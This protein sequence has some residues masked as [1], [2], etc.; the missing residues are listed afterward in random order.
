[1]QD[2]ISYLVGA[3]GFGGVLAWYCWYVTSHTLPLLMS[4]FREE[5]RLI[6]E[7]SDAQLGLVLAEYRAASER[8][9]AT[10]QDMVR[11]CSGRGGEPE[12]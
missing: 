8:M 9:S 11:H 7:H 5:T 3:L 10:I 6:R 2:L 1:M 12:P 4:H